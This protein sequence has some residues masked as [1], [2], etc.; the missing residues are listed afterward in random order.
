MTIKSDSDSITITFL[1]LLSFACCSHSAW[2]M[3]Y[4]FLNEKETQ[5][6]AAADRTFIRVHFTKTKEGWVKNNRAGQWIQAAMQKSSCCT[7][8]VLFWVFLDFNSSMTN[9]SRDL[10]ML[11]TGIQ[12]LYSNIFF[13]CFLRSL[14]RLIVTSRLRILWMYWMAELSN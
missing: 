11:P 5:L 7:D 2:V 9:G 13:F 6:W 1:F 8:D 4:V 14:R 3:L 10:S 12:C